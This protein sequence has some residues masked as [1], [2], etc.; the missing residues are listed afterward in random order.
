MP[1]EPHG[2]KLLRLYLVGYRHIE[3]GEVA[4]SLRM[5][6][7]AYAYRRIDASEQSDVTLPCLIPK[8]SARWHV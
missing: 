6:D 7:S 2:V 1:S 4:P 3:D 5:L 8:P